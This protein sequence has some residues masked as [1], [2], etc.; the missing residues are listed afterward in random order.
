MSYLIKKILFFTLFISLYLNPL[1]AKKIKV[2]ISDAESTI[3]SHTYLDFTI[4]LSN[5]PGWELL[6]IPFG[7]KIDVYYKTKEGS[8]LNNSDYTPIVEEKVTFQGN[9]TLKTIQ[10]NITDDNVSEEEEELF[11]KIYFSDGDKDE[12]KSKYL[13]KHEIATGIITDDDIE[14]SN[15]SISIADATVTET[16]KTSILNFPVTLSHAAPQGGLTISYYSVDNSAIDQIDYAKV[17]S[18]IFIQEGEDSAF[19]SVPILGNEDYEVTKKFFLRLHKSSIGHI[20]NNKAIG[21]ILDDDLEHPFSDLTLSITDSSDPIGTNQELSY[22]INVKNLGED[23]AQNVILDIKLPSD[24]IYNGVSG[25]NW[26]CQLESQKIT[27]TYDALSPNS[28]FPI[29]YPAVEVKITTPSVSREIELQAEVRSEKRDPLKN[30]NNEHESTVVSSIQTDLQIS[31]VSTPNPATP[32]SLLSYNIVIKNNSNGVAKNVR[33]KNNLPANVTFVSLTDNANNWSCSQGSTIICDYISNTG[34]FLA[35]TS[36]TI[37]INVNTPPQTGNISNSVT[38]EASTE[39]F[40]LSNNSASTITSISTDDTVGGLTPFSK[41]LQYNLYGDMTLIGNANI[42]SNQDLQYNDYANMQLIDNDQNDTTQNSSSSTLN[43][44]NAYSVK[45]AGLY[46]TGTVTTAAQ[47][48]SIRNVLFSTPSSTGYQPVTAS[49]L[50]MT[51]RANGLYLYSA[52]L[53]VTDMVQGS[54]TYSIADMTLSTGVQ[55]GGGNFGG[56]MIL[57]IYEDPNQTLSYKNISVFNGFDY[58]NRDNVQFPIDGFVTPLSGPLNASIAFFAGD[59]DPSL[60]GVGQM[61]MGKTNQFNYVGGDATNPINNL[62]NG[63][64]SEY[65][66]PKDPMVTQTFG[67]DADIIDVSSFMVNDQASTIFRFDVNT[68]S[69][70]VDYYSLSMFAFA[71]ALTVPDIRSFK[72]EAVIVDK[73]GN[74]QEI[75]QTTPIH[76]GDE[77][78][79]TLTFK[80]TGTEIARDVEIFDNFEFNNLVNVFDLN[81]FNGSNTKLSLKNSNTWDDNANCGY[82]QIQKKVWCKLDSVDINDTYKMQ[83]SIRIQDDLHDKYKEKISNIAY[84][85]YKNATTGNYIIHI[86]NNHGSFGGESNALDGGIITQRIIPGTFN[87]Q[88]TNSLY[89]TLDFALYTQIQGRDFD[90]SLVFYDENI[91][92]EQDLEGVPL[93]IELV[94]HDTNDILYTSYQY[95]PYLE[96]DET[97]SRVNILNHTDLKDI[98]AS[99]D[100]IFQITYSVT[101]NETI[102]KEKCLAQETVETCYNRQITLNP[103]VKT[104]SAQDNFSI[105]PVKFYVEIFDGNTILKDSNNSINKLSLAAGYDYRLH[106]TAE[107]YNSTLPANGYNTT[108]QENLKFNDDVIKCRDTTNPDSDFLFRNGVYTTNTFMHDNVGKYLLKLRD[109]NWTKVDEVKGDCLVNSSH[110]SF[111][112]Y[113]KSGC[114]IMKPNFDM[115]LSYYPYK[116]AVNLAMSN[117]PN[118]GHNDFIYMSDM[119]FTYNDFAIQFEGNLIA[120]SDNNVTTTNFTNGCAATES[121][122]VPS[123]NVL[124]DDGVGEAIRTAPHPREDRVSVNINRMVRFNNEVLAPINFDSIQNIN[125]AISISADNFTRDNNGTSTIELKYNIEK[126]NTLPINPVQMTFQN[127]LLN[128]PLA[129]SSAAGFMKPNPHV[130]TGREDLNNTIR[131]FYFTRVVSE[132]NDYPRVNINV[133]PTVRTPL[134]V[135]MYCRT[136]TPNYCV[137]TNIIAHTNLGATDREAD[138]WYLSTDHN[139]LLD[140]NV[141]NLTSN[142]P[143]VTI[144]PDDNANPAINILMLNNG[145]H[146]RVMER[147]NNCPAPGRATITINTS[148][149]LAFSPSQ[150]VVKCTN[151]NRSDW[152]GIGKTG[153]TLNINPETSKT[154][155]MDW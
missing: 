28:S 134:N 121:M 95:Y 69:G 33:L 15:L 80:N 89:N 38:I 20:S 9:E 65:G 113:E 81:V 31:L 86:T 72:K 22:F 85:N 37:T 145:S 61:Q 151:L 149:V 122:L 107:K 73:H 40:D 127:F 60:G 104:V 96:N 16:N 88:R 131:N 46:W 50:N 34:N 123:V 6:G 155:K 120:L 8:A 130:P 153:H 83:F 54:G 48:Q 100:V 118:S 75:E 143:I 2:N 152:S 109:N 146:G 106:V 64:I 36:S 116:F 90:Y 25:Q 13:I 140:G 114:D 76:E 29:S 43:L 82:D 128:A 55:G 59:G 53:D 147:F 18:S 10:V 78:L 66:I 74:K 67:V 125:Q 112:E 84:I 35:H 32:S 101:N 150:Y 92:K 133:N 135:D 97:S 11:L 108:V 139:G 49:K 148:P 56:W 21:T 5:A 41:L 142:L 154:S 77:I 117:L 52:F 26:S 42:G 4:R 110:V 111:R 138:G 30:N 63:S 1:Y 19:I 39:D 94:D 27:C 137:N 14:V 45:W 115:N 144:S 141:T 99:R 12:Y 124:V 91:T 132:R 71:T 93:K 62:L 129:S 47:R 24:S 57:V 102:I 3:E 58:I 51:T 68:P 87:I 70:G 119:N 44:N 98:N 7:D 17:D 105:R 126:H 136:N 79:Y 103:K 23:I